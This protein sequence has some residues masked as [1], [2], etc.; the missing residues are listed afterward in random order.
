MVVGQNRG[1]VPSAIRVVQNEGV[2][3]DPTQIVQNTT[4]NC[5]QIKYRLFSVSN[6]ITL[7]LFPDDSACR[8][9]GIFRREVM[10][11]FLQCPSGFDIEGPRCTCD[12]HLQKYTTNCSV[13]NHGIGRASNTFWIGTDNYSNGTYKGL[14]LYSGKCPFDYCTDDSIY[15]TL[16]NLDVQCDNN[17]SGTLCGSCRSG[18]SLT[19]GNLHCVENCTNKYL[20]LILPFALAGMALV[21]FLLLLNVSVASGTINGLIFYANV[22]QANRLIFFPP[23]ETNILTVFIA[24]LNL[25]LG[26]KTCFYDGMD[27]YGFTWLQFVFPFYIWF[28]IGLIVMVTHYSEKV[29]RVLGNNPI[30]ALATLLLLS[31]S[32]ILRTT[33]MAL[34]VTSLEYPDRNKS[35]WLYDGNV[36]YFQ[37]AHHIVLGLFAIAML[38]FLFL[39]YTFL[40]LFGHWLQAYSN[41]WI[42]SW[43]NRIKPFMDAYHAPYKKGTRYWTGFLLLVRCILFLIFA[44]NA[45]ADDNSNLLSVTTASA[46]L[47]ALASLHGGIYENTYTNVVEISYV[48]NLCIFAVATY[49]VKVSGTGQPVLAYLSVSIAFATFIFIMLYYV[50][51]AFSKTLL[52]KKLPPVRTFISKFITQRRAQEID[53]ERVNLVGNHANGRQNDLAA[54]APTTSFIDIRE[55][56]PLLD[57]ETRGKNI[58]NRNQT[59]T[60]NKNKNIF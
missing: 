12:K 31:Y 21:V 58:F 8:D 57:H 34:S 43:L 10:I 44:L 48:L 11:E 18:Y 45:F 30:A 2:E 40:F 54:R 59:S 36:P 35:V 50:Y 60:Q 14:I 33:I 6:A 16:D 39:P 7:T 47:L 26:I 46:I 17:H 32:K 24:W 22:V 41:W 4:N 9:G 27:A 19:L 23:G 28:L 3:I 37:S 1:I 25:D 56:E 55:Y 42:L 13:D 38:V 51:L 53:E 52:G 20:S 49:H 5:T 15:V 29:T